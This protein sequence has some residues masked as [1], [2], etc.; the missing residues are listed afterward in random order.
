MTNSILN[1]TSTIKTPVILADQQYLIT[2]SVDFF[3]RKNGYH[4]VATVQNFKDLLELAHQHQNALVVFDY[5]NIID[6]NLNLFI[7]LF[8][9]NSG[10]KHLI[11]THHITRSDLILIKKNNLQQIAFKA[12]DEYNLLKAVQ[13]AINNRK[14]YSPGIIKLMVDTFKADSLSVKHLT[15]TEISIVQ[16][17]ASGLTTKA[18]ANRRKISPHTVNTHRKNI[19]KKLSINNSS[20]LITTALKMGWINQVEYYI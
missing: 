14:Y 17:I 6:G 20:D 2:D 15:P 9:S 1:S 12:I 3:L 16:N 19:F 7:Q 8:K 13:A 4:V 18:I 11:L 5:Q 10:L